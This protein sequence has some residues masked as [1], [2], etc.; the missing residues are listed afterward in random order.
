MK[1]FE[2]GDLVEANGPTPQLES[3]VIYRVAEIVE[4]PTPFGSFVTY[5]L[6]RSDSGPNGT[7]TAV[8]NAHLLLRLVSKHDAPDASH[9]RPEPTR[10]VLFSFGDGQLHRGFTDDS[11]WNGWLNVWVTPETHAEVLKELGAA[12]PDD[13]ENEGGLST[14]EIGDDG[15]VSY[16]YGFCPEEVDRDTLERDSAQNVAAG[17]GICDACGAA[18]LSDAYCPSCG[19]MADDSKLG[20]CL[21][22]KAPTYFDGSRWRH[23]DPA[24]ACF[25]HAAEP[26]SDAERAALGKAAQS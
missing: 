23:E 9:L 3:S 13:D 20:R 8:T 18:W 22:C 11:R 1:T 14:L 2:V 26:E 25:A 21:D 17:P 5:W 24:V 12:G 10:R 16:A 19:V 6:Q 4:R 15:L 7:K